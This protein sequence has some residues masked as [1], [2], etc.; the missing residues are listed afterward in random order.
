MLKSIEDTVDSLRDPRWNSPEQNPDLTPIALDCVQNGQ[1]GVFVA[2]PN[3]PEPHGAQVWSDCIAGKYGTIGPYVA[4]VETIHQAMGS[5]NFNVMNHLQG[6]MEPLDPG[7]DRQLIFTELQ[8]AC[9]IAAYYHNRIPFP[10]DRPI[11]PEDQALLDQSKQ[12][13]EETVD[14]LNAQLKGRIVLPTN[15]FKRKGK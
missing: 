2:H 7:P 13:Y 3:D 15:P 8:A 1:P 12:A 10:W 9:S 14:Y 4:P 5:Q 6:L 11:T